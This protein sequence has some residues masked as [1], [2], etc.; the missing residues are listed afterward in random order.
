[1]K[2]HWQ[3]VALVV[4]L[5]AVAAATPPP[6]WPTDRD[7]YVRVGHELLIPGCTEI[8]CFRVLVPWLIEALPGSSDSWWTT[9]AVLCQ[10]GA[11]VAMGRLVTV[12]GAKARTAAQV[13]WLTG[14]GAGALYTL[15]DPHTSDPLM[16]LLAPVLMVC[17]LTARPRSATM[18]ATVG[19]L[20]KEFAVVPL[21]VMGLT[22]A[23]EQR[24]AEAWQLIRAAMVPAAVWAVWQVGLRVGLG[25]SSVASESG[26]WDKGSYVA[27][28]LI[29]IGPGLAA[30]SMLMALGALWVLWP[31]G[32]VL[33]D[34]SMRRQLFAA[35]PI[36][37]VFCA[38]QQPDRALWNFAF[39]IMPAV[40]VVLERTP[41]RLGWLLVVAQGLA[42]L[43]SGAQ[44]TFVPPT[45]ITLPVAGA[46]AVASVWMARRRQSSGTTV[47]AGAS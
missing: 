35:T 29:N 11:A 30:S 31:A 36:V 8:H 9:Y 4:L 16:Q 28:W 18:L 13:T 33:G 15:F 2:P 46:L 38:A 25:Y 32:L 23:V 34:R 39:L 26:A 22:R 40:A 3:F 47:M 44:L 43:R 37:L 45:R 12:L 20:A 21:A 7:I 24:R 14:L 10:A 19:V 5:G 17:L 42:N 1:M 6:W 27:F 41:A